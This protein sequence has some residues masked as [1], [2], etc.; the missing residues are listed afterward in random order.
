MKSTAFVSSLL[1]VCASLA[2]LAHTQVYTVTDLG[3]FAGDYSVGAALNDLGQVV[4]SSDVA[5]GEP[6]AFL[7]TKESGMQ[8]LNPAGLAFSNALGINNQGKVV[9]SAGFPDGE[10]FQTRAFL[11]TRRTGMQDLGIAGIAS[12]INNFSKVAGGSGEPYI[13]TRAKGETKLGSLGSGDGTAEALNDFG[14]V[15]GG[16][17]TADFD[18]HAFLWTNAQGMIDLGTLGGCESEAMGINDLGQ[19]VG[20]SDTTDCAGNGH[21]FLWTRES[22]MQDLGEPPNT[23]NSYAAAINLFGLVAGGAC[24]AP[25]TTQESSHAFLWS[26]AT[27][28]IDLNNLI[29]RNSGWILENAAAINTW[30]QITG[31]GYIGGQYHAFLLS[32]IWR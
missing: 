26:R 31:M 27:G 30:G 9:G 24:L 23:T 16:S 2:P 7:W 12:S 29:P 11:W 5:N 4:G 14:L 28:W 25:C 32:P 17:Y 21:G 10:F 15:V 1:F 3:S 20:S 6:H 18:Y 8:D 22:G 19:I 13:W